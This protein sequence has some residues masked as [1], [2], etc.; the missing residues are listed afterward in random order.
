MTEEAY[1]FSLN[2]TLREIKS[3][4]PEVSTSFIFRDGKVV[5]TDESISQETTESIM[6]DVSA[7]K[8][9]AEA[10]GGLESLSFRGNNGAANVYCI[11]GFSLVTVASK[12]VDEKYLTSLVRVL[13][14]TVLRLVEKIH[15]DLN[16]DNSVRE[17][18]LE[19][20]DV[21]NKEETEQK[22]T[23]EPIEEQTTEEP[24]EEDKEEAGSVAEEQTEIIQNA[25]L[26]APPVTQLMVENLGGIQF[27]SDSVRLEKSVLMQWKELYGDKP[28]ESVEVK[29]QNG[30]TTQC[31]FKQIKNL[32]GGN[33]GIVQIPKRVQMA[34]GAKKGELVTIKPVIT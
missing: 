8:E 20:A 2:N 27:L 21:E 17:A 33:K 23:E 10:I 34:L 6:N 1:S 29:T 28:V 26:P 32:K 15:P 31:K 4:C 12:D 11:E 24:T 14:P 22:P 30:K 13:V 5:A 16:R 3:S 9:R 7:I 18:E 19:R 25:L